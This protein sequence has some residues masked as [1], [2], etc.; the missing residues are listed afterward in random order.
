M[1]LMEATEKHEC[2]SVAVQV[3]YSLINS[4]E[5]RLHE[6]GDVCVMLRRITTHCK[7]L[8]EILT[9]T[10]PAEVVWLKELAPFISSDIVV[11]WLCSTA[12]VF[13]SLSNLSNAILFSTSACDFVQYLSNTREGDIV[14]ANVFNVHGLTLSMTCQYKSSILYH[15]EATKIYTASC[16]WK[17]PESY[18]NLGNVYKSLGQYNKA[19]KYL[20]KALIIS[21]KMFGEEHADVASS[22][23][24]LGDFYQN[25]GQYTEAKNTSR[26][27]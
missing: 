2:L 18:N 25:L 8:Y 5:N 24:N 14:K 13:Q 10:F 1:S 12:T 23:N 21:K 26:R 11:S 15:E 20:E 4:E 22:Y 27:H 6:S 17:V 3:F 9:S 7:V 16:V 19:K